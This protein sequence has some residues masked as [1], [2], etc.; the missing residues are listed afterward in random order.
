MECVTLR[1]FILATI[2]HSLITFKNERNS[3]VIIICYNRRSS[4]L[5]S[6][7]LLMEDVYRLSQDINIYNY[8]HIYREANRT[9]ECIAM[10]CIFNTNPNI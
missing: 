9:T 10:K 5:S 2:Y 8:G 7:I 4:S 3:V 6:I 1:N